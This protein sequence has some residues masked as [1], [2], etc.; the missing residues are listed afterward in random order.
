ML[1]A[2]GADA[3]RPLFIFLQLL[4]R[5]SERI[6]YIRLG[7]AEHQAP[8]AHALSDV[9][10][11]RVHTVPWHCSQLLPTRRITLHYFAVCLEGGCMVYRR[12]GQR[13]ELWYTRAISIVVPRIR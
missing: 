5:H 1:Q 7:H 11:S 4:E 9:S 8:R 10:V 13:R 3:V 12:S 6:G 2:A